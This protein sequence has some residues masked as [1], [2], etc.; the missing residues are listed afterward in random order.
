M[1]LGTTEIVPDS[2]TI[3][4]FRERLAETGTDQK[5]WAGMQRQL[6]A[7]KLKVQKRNHAGCHIHNRWSWP[8]QS[9]Y[10]SWR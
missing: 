9:R 10:S 4:K 7:M 3:W 6:D 1:F 8:C 2:T 5:I